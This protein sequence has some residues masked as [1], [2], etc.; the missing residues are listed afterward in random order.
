MRDTAGTSDL[1]SYGRTRLH[2]TRKDVECEAKRP[3]GRLGAPPSCRR[4][5]TREKAVSGVARSLLNPPVCRSRTSVERSTTA[6]RAGQPA[7]KRDENS[8][9]AP[10]KSGKRTVPTPLHQPRRTDLGSSFCIQVD[11]WQTSESL[12]VM[13]G[14]VVV[15]LEQVARASKLLSRAGTWRCGKHIT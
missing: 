2:C 13:K 1:C 6:R 7:E 10:Q 12:V 5:Q 8:G 9:N 11:V 4:V 3:G 14:E 15:E